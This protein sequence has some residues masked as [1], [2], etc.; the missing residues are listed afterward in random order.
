MS[1]GVTYYIF[2]NSDMFELSICIKCIKK[3]LHITSVFQIFYYYCS[4][5][6]RLRYC[7]YFL[8]REDK[9]SGHFCFNSPYFLRTSINIFFFVEQHVRL[10]IGKHSAGPPTGKRC[11][12]K[13]DKSKRLTS[14]VVRQQKNHLFTKYRVIN[15]D[16]SYSR[17]LLCVCVFCS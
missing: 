12:F 9:K 8:Q 15:M 17:Q 10:Q 4:S 16:L 5:K 3:Q 1:Y 11:V 6:W 7:I 13:L 14:G 2:T